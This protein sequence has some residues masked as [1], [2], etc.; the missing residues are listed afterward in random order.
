MSVMGSNFRRLRPTLVRGHRFYTGGFDLMIC[1][2][3]GVRPAS[4]Q[5]TRQQGG[6]RASNYLCTQCARD[7]G[8]IGGGAGASDPFAMLQNLIHQ[9]Q[10]GP[11]GSLFG[12]LSREA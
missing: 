10:G 6:Q 7:L 2:N 12:A 9:Q 8:M 5:V 3:C 1:E 11:G 4:V